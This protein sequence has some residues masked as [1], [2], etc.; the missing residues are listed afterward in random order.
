MAVRESELTREVGE[1]REQVNL[2][3]ARTAEQVRD[4]TRI[5][6]EYVE[7]VDKLVT[8]CKGHV[9]AMQTLREQVAKL[10]SDVEYR[11]KRIYELMEQVA[12]LTRERDEL[13]EEVDT[14]RGMNRNQARLIDD[15]QKAEKLHTETPAPATERDNLE[16]AVIAMLEDWDGKFWKGFDHWVPQLRKALAGRL[17]VPAPEPDAA[18][19][20]IDAAV[21]Y[22]NSGNEIPGVQ[23]RMWTALCKA[24]ERYESEVAR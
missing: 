11:D 8:T 17:Q 3:D 14:V 15:L 19:A 21:R 20:V 22:I 10:T 6:T 9:A 18:R 7:Q 5:A 23:G 4:K 12:T 24:V 2:S 1:L 16:Y 13:R